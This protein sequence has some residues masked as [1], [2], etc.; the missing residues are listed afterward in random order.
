M[1]AK[2]T[3]GRIGWALCTM[4]FC[5]IVVSLALSVW[6]TASGLDASRLG[7]GKWL[8][9]FLPV[10]LVAFPA[11]YAVLRAVPR[12]TREGRPL[13]GK[14]FCAFL[15]M[16]FPLMYGG[17]LL[18]NLLG[19]LLGALRLDGR[20]EN[21]LLKFA[22]DQNPIKVLVMVVLAPL[23][24]EWFFRKQIID[25]SARY[26]EKTAILFS[27]VVF[28]LFHQNLYQYFYAFGLGLLF[29]YVYIRTRRL[30]YSVLLHMTV[31]FLGSVVAPL[32]LSTV[33]MDEWKRLSSGALP[34]EQ[35]V[36]ALLPGV[37]LLG[38]YVLLLIGLSIA[39]LVLL[40]THARRL[41]FL[42]AEEELPK[43]GRFLTVY[44]GIGTVL[45]VL[46]CA[47]LS[48]AALAAS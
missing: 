21:P 43:K 22:L 31:N 8:V 30:R 15:L 46:L 36:T 7:I 41:M 23:F 16:C 29:A 4:T 18:G 28:A 32:V 33:D 25:R 17:S 1:T 3:F 39:G 27:A 20:A 11:G 9:S 10:Y 2:Q 48:I 42:P 35:T 19:S 47:F 26:G 14:S 24:E 13:S 40:I 38:L 34:D 37:G 45:F 6:M 12:E 5:L 44:G